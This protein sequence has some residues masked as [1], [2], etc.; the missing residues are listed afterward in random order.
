MLNKIS[1]LKKL[2]Y[3]GRIFIPK[4]IR[5]YYGG[6]EFVSAPPEKKNQMP[7]G[8]GIYSPPPVPGIPDATPDAGSATLQ[9]P[10]SAANPA[11]GSTM[12]A[13]IGGSYMDRIKGFIQKHSP[14]HMPS[15]NTQKNPE[16][17]G[18][19]NNRFRK[20]RPYKYKTNDMRAKPPASGNVQ[21]L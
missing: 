10:G 13:P 19:P 9:T 11:L 4:A 18:A 6:A 15:M 7:I 8:G 2:A 21:Y 1:A 20:W 16:D 14:N 3:G 17:I 12:R 5:K